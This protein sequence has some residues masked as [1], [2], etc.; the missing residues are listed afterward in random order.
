MPD[1]SFPQKKEIFQQKRKRGTLIGET[2]VSE[3]DRAWPF[4]SWLGIPSFIY[5]CLFEHTFMSVIYVQWLYFLFLFLFVNSALW[6]SVD[7]SADILCLE[8]KNAKGWISTQTNRKHLLSPKKPYGPFFGFGKYDDDLLFASSQHILSSGFSFLN[9]KWLKMFI[10]IGKMMVELC[11]AAMLFR[12]WR[13]LNW[14]IHGKIEITT[15]FQ[16]WMPPG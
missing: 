16:T 10:G 3:L 9:R 7:F 4:L 6:T 14:K 8:T 15:I 5:F 2:E 13:Y 1:W 12:V 11:S